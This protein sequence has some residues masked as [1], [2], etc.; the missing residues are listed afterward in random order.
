MILKITPETRT[1][2][3]RL[4]TSIASSSLRPKMSALSP[5]TT[6]RSRMGATRASSDSMSF[7]TSSKPPRPPRPMDVVAY[8]ELRTMST[9][10]YVQPTLTKI[11]RRWYMVVRKCAR[12][13]T[14]FLRSKFSRDWKLYYGQGV[15]RSSCVADTIISPWLQGFQLRWADAAHVV[16][17]EFVCS[18]YRS[19]RN[20][21]FCNTTHLSPCR[22]RLEGHSY[23][24]PTI[25]SQ[26]ARG[27]G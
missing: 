22:R 19:Q 14:S 18:L 15:S 6:V 9:Q 24:H 3:N 27:K 4:S 12:L 5:A 7:L 16:H 17:Q 10:Y 20:T 1:A 2:S 21:A 26:H 25:L 11:S 8:N 13:E 23:D